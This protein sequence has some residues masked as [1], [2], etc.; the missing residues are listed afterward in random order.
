MLVVGLE[1]GEFEDLRFRKCY[2][3][4]FGFIRWSDEL[5][6]SYLV[7][8]SMYGFRGLIAKRRNLIWCCKEEGNEGFFYGV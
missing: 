2:V 8:E 7:E 5:F 3:V 1:Y 6:D 4:V